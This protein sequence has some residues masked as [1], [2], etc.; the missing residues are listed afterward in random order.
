[1][2]IL[3]SYHLALEF[4]QIIAQHKRPGVE[5][6]VARDK[7]DFER[8]LA[9]ADVLI[10]APKP[11]EVLDRASLLKLHIVPFAGVNRA[12]LTWYEDRGV[13]L[14]S[15]HGN[16]R[17]VAERAVAL[18]Y[19]AAGRMVEF[20]RGLRR[21]C[22]HRRE[23]R[24]S[25][26]EYWRSIAG[27]RIAVL[28]TGEIGRTVAEYLSPIAGEIVGFNRSGNDPS[29]SFAA[30]TQDIEEA[31]RG[32]IAV[33]STLPLTDK[34]RGLLT[35]AG[36]AMTDRAVFINVGR[37]EVVVEE[38]LYRALTDGTLYAAGLDT[39]YRY[40]DPPWDEGENAMPASLPFHEL[41]NVVL[42]PHAASHTESGKQGQL[43]GALELLE[44][45]L[46]SGA[47]ARTVVPGPGY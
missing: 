26:F 27:G 6:V 16:A 15:S 39:W 14:A 33:I 42:S 36:L 37:A 3:F 24:V 44:E 29:A 47:V 23:D 40:P 30:V 7:N 13:L 10:A 43:I 17:T 34:T 4:P 28:G 46:D 1:M 32:A 18:L 31:L 8:E 22:W 38:D 12:P 19:A 25:P 2:R 41:D 5:L 21:G 11:R 20:D 9:S 35:P 45:F